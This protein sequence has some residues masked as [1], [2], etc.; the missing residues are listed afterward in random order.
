MLMKL[1]S[2]LLSKLEIEDGQKFSAQGVTLRANHCPGHTKDHVAF[3]LEEEDAMFTGDN[4]LGHGTA[5]FEDLAAYM[6]SLDRMRKQFTGRAYPGHGAVTDDGKNRIT[7]YIQH[8]N[9]REREVLDVLAEAKKSDNDS[10]A[11]RRT[12]MDIVKIVYKDY[13]E[14]LYGPAAWGVLQ[15]LEKLAKEGKTSQSEDGD[16]WQIAN[17]PTAMI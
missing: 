17:K 3:V 14:N 16:Q 10:H 4:V 5:V 9:Q 6:T 11:G 7:E 13:P 1:I 2:S 12:S 8:R 15:I